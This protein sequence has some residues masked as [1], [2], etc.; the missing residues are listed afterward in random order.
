MNDLHNPAWKERSPIT[1][2]DLLHSAYS[3][4]LD[5]VIKARQDQGPWPDNGGGRILAQVLNTM[6]HGQVQLPEDSQ[7]IKRQLHHLLWD[8]SEQRERKE[9]YPLPHAWID[10]FASLHP[11]LVRD[12]VRSILDLRRRVARSSRECDMLLEAIRLLIEPILQQQ[13]SPSFDMGSGI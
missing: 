3:A 2:D 8:M 7:K 9:D 12:S 11:P 4:D 6:L 5:L 1:L 13:P 10:E